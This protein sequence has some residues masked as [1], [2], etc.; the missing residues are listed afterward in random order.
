MSR[1]GSLFNVA[2]NWHTE[3]ETVHAVLSAAAVH[4]RRRRRARS[5]VRLR[6]HDFHRVLRVLP[7]PRHTH[8]QQTGSLLLTTRTKERYNHKPR[9]T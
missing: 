2:K 5:V 8:R 3:V 9:A 6:H 4:L 7:R 1:I